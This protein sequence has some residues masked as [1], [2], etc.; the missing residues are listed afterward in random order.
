MKCFDY[1]LQDSDSEGAMN[2]Y[3]EKFLMWRFQKVNYG[4]MSLMPNYSPPVSSVMHSP[5][6]TQ[7]G[8][9]HVR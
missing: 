4:S 6:P 3:H 1:Y 5:L 8:E 7:A 2:I 9:W